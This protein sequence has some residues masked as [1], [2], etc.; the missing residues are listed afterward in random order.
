MN[1]FEWDKIGIVF[2]EDQRSL[3]T[4]LIDHLNPKLNGHFHSKKYTE[5]SFDV[6]YEVIAWVS[7]ADHYV[8][9]QHKEMLQLKNWQTVKER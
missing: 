5:P 1:N 3:E 6:E 4:D 2:S 7:F 9:N 8:F